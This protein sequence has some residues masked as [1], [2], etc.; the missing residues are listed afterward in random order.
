MQK[1]ESND[2]HISFWSIRFHT[3]EPQKNFWFDFMELNSWFVM[4]INPKTCIK[5]CE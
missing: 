3:F 2:F 5:F 4:H 1:K